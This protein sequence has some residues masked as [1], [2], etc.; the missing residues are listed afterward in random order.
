MIKGRIHS[1]ESLGTLDGPGLRTVVF[2]QGCSLNCKFC[3]NPDCLPNS[4]DNVFTPEE[5][6]ATVMKNAP[7]WKGQNGE[8][9][10]VTF[11]GG[12]PLLQADFIHEC[13]ILLKQKG[14]HITVDSCF[15]VPVKAIEK[16]L[17]DIDYYM[18]SF[19]H[20]DKEKHKELTGQDNTRIKENILFLDNKVHTNKIRIR[21]LIIPEITDTK[22]A[23]KG[24]VEFVKSIRHLDCVEL[25]AYGD[26][27]KQKWIETY[28]E[29]PFA[30]VR[31]AERAD[32]E[33]VTECLKKYEIPL[34]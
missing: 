9:G 34:K 25:L 13:A 18:I 30:G 4:T 19:K 2:M 11:S 22:E 3:H 8:Q 21:Y 27:G 5:L 6:V 23:L 10:G 31:N 12:E 16:I 28:G 1:I 20:H 26:H 33:K 17:E 15:F 14:V 32:V 24:F 7:Y 29:Y